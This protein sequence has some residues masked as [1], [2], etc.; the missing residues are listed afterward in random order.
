[1][2]SSTAQ[3]E[4]RIVH[5]LKVLRAVWPAMYHPPR[6]PIGRIA[7][8]ALFTHKDDSPRTDDLPTIDTIVAL[9]M[10]TLGLLDDWASMLV[11][12]RSLSHRLP[13]TT[14]AIGMMNLLERHARWLSGHDA[15]QELASELSDAAHRCQA[16]AFPYRRDDMRIGFCTNHIGV[17]GVSTLCGSE[18]RVVAAHPGEIR[19]PRCGL[20]DTLDGWI[21]RLVGQAELVTAEQLVPIL[22]QRMG[23]VVH[24]TT[25]RT[26]VH[27]GELPVAATDSA[28]RN[29]YDRQVAFLVIKR[30]DARHSL[31]LSRA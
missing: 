11:E 21:K 13:I 16:V 31:T 24:P 1:M 14:D 10:D 19:C 30:R 4:D 22:H 8:R 9:R 6:Q 12:Q 27:R 23:V 20:E 5:S 25:I 28:G 17:E 26:W 18:I 2:N 29:L 7:R 15:A 3:I